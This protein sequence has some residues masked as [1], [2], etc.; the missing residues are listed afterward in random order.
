MHMNKWTN[1]LIGH[2]QLKA[3][4]RSFGLEPSELASEIYLGL[5]RF[6]ERVEAVLLDSRKLHSI[7]RNKSIDLYRKRK[8]LSSQMLAIQQNLI[9]C[10]DSN[11]EV[12]TASLQSECVQVCR[13]AVLRLPVKCREAVT[14][15]CLDGLKLRDYA[16]QQGITE[17]AVKNRLRRARGMLRSDAALLR[18]IDLPSNP[19]Q[20][21]AE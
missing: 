21:R 19:I 16:V 10:T 7:A 5:A 3:I 8:R 6:P 15:V 4:A 2:G 14:S 17:N 18:Y 1:L 9:E 20:Q 13:R 11:S 12:E